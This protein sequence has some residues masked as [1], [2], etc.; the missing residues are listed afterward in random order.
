MCAREV[1]TEY[2][3]LT[4]ILE[5]KIKGHLEIHPDLRFL[6]GIFIIY[7]ACKSTESGMQFGCLGERLVERLCQGVIGWLCF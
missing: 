5:I 7:R 2:E 6:I 1:E 3:M 4:R